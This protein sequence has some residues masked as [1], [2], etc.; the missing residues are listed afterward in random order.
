MKNTY[1]MQKGCGNMQCKRENMLWNYK[2]G[3]FE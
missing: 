2:M 1:L 3:K